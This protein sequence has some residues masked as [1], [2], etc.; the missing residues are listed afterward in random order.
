MES[1]EHSVDFNTDTDETADLIGR[2]KEDFSRFIN[3]EIQELVLKNT[4]DY[5]EKNLLFIKALA[6]ILK[7]SIAKEEMVKAEKLYTQHIWW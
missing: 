4:T 2:I 5:S 6:P 3:G 1:I 7:V